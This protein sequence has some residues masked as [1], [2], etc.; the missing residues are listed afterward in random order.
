M[1]DPKILVVDDEPGI[2]NLVTS[3][4][5]AEGYDYQTAADGLSALKAARTYQPD[6]I[7]L[8]I[9]LPG[10]DGIEVLSNLRRESD[11]YVIMLT[12]KSEE[13]D[14][15]VGLSVGADDYLTKPFSPRE[16][17]ARIKAAL[18]RLR[19][20]SASQQPEMI[21][22]EHLRIDPASR[23][24]WAEGELVDLTSTEFDLLLVLAEHRGIVMSR[25]QLLEK[26]WEGEYFGDYRVVDVHL[27]HIRQK[28]GEHHNITTVRGVG[29]R[30]EKEKS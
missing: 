17:M 8:D 30:F 21:T 20:G 5:K 10:M 7:V 11:V 14:K 9:M 24:V 22:T 19:T 1:T 18:R 12:A 29:Y 26:V 28:L 2:L 25:E 23:Q 13:T 4:L 27:G 3:Y 16:L 15:V 6:L